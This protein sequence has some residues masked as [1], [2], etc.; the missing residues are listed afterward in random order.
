VFI[1]EIH[2]AITAALAEAGEHGVTV[3]P[4]EEARP[5]MI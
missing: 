3:A 5:M 1:D 2:E 4:R